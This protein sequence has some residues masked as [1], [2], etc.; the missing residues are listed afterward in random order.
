MQTSPRC[1][2]LFSPLAQENETE[3]RP[4]QRAKAAAPK[5][6][7][8]AATGARTKRSRAPAQSYANMDDDDDEE[9][10]EVEEVCA[11]AV[12]IGFCIYPRAPRAVDFRDS[13]FARCFRVQ[14]R[15]APSDSSSKR[16]FASRRRM[17]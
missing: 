16:S 12:P 10:D 15:G 7:S 17:R 9:S 8:S 5:A 1:T 4:A 13:P 2:P 6:A 11:L 14:V 3:M